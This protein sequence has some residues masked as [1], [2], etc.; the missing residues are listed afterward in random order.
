MAIRFFV[1]LF[2]SLSLAITLS[3]CSNSNDINTFTEVVPAPPAP[4]PQFSAQLSRTEY[5]IPHIVA[6]DWGSL[7]YGVGNAYAED[8]YCLLMREI[9]FARGESSRFLGDAG[10]QQSDLLY[11]LLNGDEATLRS[12]WYDPQPQ[13]V[14]DLVEGYVA[15]YNRYFRDTGAA[16][17]ATGDE[18]CRDAD[19]AREITV[20]DL[21][22]YLKKLTLQ[23]STDNGTIRRIIT[24]VEAPPSLASSTASKKALANAPARLPAMFSK[25]HDPSASGSNA[26]A[27]GRDFSQTGAGILLGNPH[28]PWQGTG[29]FYMIHLTIPGVYD[30]MG[31]TLHGIPVVSIGFNKDV[32]WTHT[33]SFANRLTLYEL[34][35]NPDNP[36][37][38]SYD[39]EMRDIT[40]ETVDIQVLQ[41]DG[42]LST[43]SKTFYSSHY[44]LMV[45]LASQSPLIG[46][47]PIGFS[48]TAFSVRDANLDNTMGIG[49]WIEAGQATNISEFSD[50]LKGIAFP[51]VHT[52]AADRNGDA[53]YGDISSIPHV[54]QAKLDD[55]V[56]GP[57]A[58]LLTA[59]TG[60]LIIALDGSRSA[61]EW[62]NDADTPEGRN[63]FGYDAL[64]KLFST[65]YVA[66]SNNSYW[67]SNAD[68]PL[69]GFP[70]IMGALG[71]ENEQ[72][73]LRT[74]ITHQMVA[75][76]MNA[77]DGLGAAPGFTLANM[78]E[79][80][81][82]NRVLGAEVALDDVL[83][84]CPIA[85][86]SL[87][88]GVVVRANQACTL[89][90]AWDRRTNIDSDGAQ[91][92]TEFWRELKRDFD[93]ASAL[94]IE[95]QDL[96]TIDFNPA[97]PIATPSGFALAEGTNYQR[98]AEAL[99][100]AIENLETANVDPGA[101][102]GEVQFAER[103]GVR[104]PIHGGL[105]DMGVFGVI[106]GGLSD[107]GYRSIN[108]G[109]T[110]IQAVSWDDTECPL[111]EGILVPS[112]SNDPE[113]D[114][115]SDQT[116]AYSN[117]EWI[118]FPFCESDVEAQEISSSL[119]EE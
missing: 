72:Q 36:L 44:G 16:N 85:D 41:G 88:A 80:M 107:G 3:S 103:N 108:G 113:S 34:Q 110:Y 101:P 20:I 48:G 21:M 116:E 19:W 81:Y 15:G 49:Q 12:E 117:K 63:V 27:V 45:D 55:C 66:N 119:L 32:A 10:N 92:F 89:L 59:A 14:K 114:H 35:L 111:A 38:Y 115:F 58:P 65:E 112:L 100:K 118:Q 87:D 61:C 37:Q 43:V 64:P 79:L 68:S 93:P 8:N 30:A 83:A 50:A 51:W 5:G 106:K 47:W 24:D 17:L 82:S 29:Q 7:G 77:S 52:I 2:C 54:D 26:I 84:E 98:I 97:D 25:M 74:R 102:F 78:K 1:T 53:F 56:S 28:Q 73:F 104:I 40:S 11:T 31:A 91:V 105:D 18:G 109:N 57:V 69:T 46:G 22:Q 6:D 42:S 9:L 67:V 96:W 90:A 70:I 99:S 33:V 94:E 75:E 76:R 86:P 4:E 39:G 23:G 62:G 71:G 60:S 95:Q 13:E